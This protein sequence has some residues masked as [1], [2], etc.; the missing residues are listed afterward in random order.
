MNMVDQKEKFNYVN[1]Y[2]TQN[3]VDA[4]ARYL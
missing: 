1:V 3:T 2:V 4:P